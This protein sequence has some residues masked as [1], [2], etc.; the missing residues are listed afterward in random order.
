MSMSLFTNYSCWLNSEK[1]LPEYGACVW[2]ELAHGGD[3][4]YFI[5]FPMYDECLYSVLLLNSDMLSNF[6]M[7][8]ILHSECERDY[9]KT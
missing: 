6:G 3:M 4:S 1:I 2:H 8:K 5:F 9:Q 7:C